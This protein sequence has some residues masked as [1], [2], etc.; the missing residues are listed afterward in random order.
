MGQSEAAE[1]IQK[2]RE[3]IPANK[4]S[5]KEHMVGTKKRCTPVKM[6]TPLS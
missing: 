1:G 3:I 4:N 2:S 5:M 6:I